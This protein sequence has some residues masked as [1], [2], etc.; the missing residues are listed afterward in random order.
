MEVEDKYL[1]EKEY[2]ELKEVS[3]NLP[4]I[5]IFDFELLMFRLQ[6]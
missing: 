4:H 3:E 2:F 1:L 5:F 6:N